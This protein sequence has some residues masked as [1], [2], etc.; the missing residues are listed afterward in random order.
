MTTPV[1]QWRSDP[2]EEEKLHSPVWLAIGINRSRLLIRAC[3]LKTDA[4]Q[5]GN[6]NTARGDGFNYTVCGTNI[7]PPHAVDRT[8]SVNSQLPVGGAVPPS[9]LENLEGTVSDIA[10]AA[11]VAPPKKGTA[12]TA[13]SSAVTADGTSG[14]GISGTDIIHSAD[15]DDES[16][17]SSSDSSSDA[18]ERS[19]ERCDYLAF[20]AAA[21]EF[22][23]AACAFCNTTN[24]SY[25]AAAVFGDAAVAFANEAIEFG[26]KNAALSADG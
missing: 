9:G 11:V 3:A 26:K 13:A 1:S 14:A 23:A 17:G 22:R 24:I 19:N 20:S 6:S 8:D 18:D 7:H 5:W 12:A 2:D 25:G 21:N 15:A 10:T 16:D 4:L